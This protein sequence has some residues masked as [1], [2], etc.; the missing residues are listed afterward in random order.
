MGCMNV[1]AHMRLLLRYHFH[2]LKIILAAALFGGQ[3]PAFAEPA[4][5]SVPSRTIEEATRPGEPSVFGTIALPVR[6]QPTST[7]WTKLMNASLDQPRLVA[8][9]AEARALTAEDKVAFV[10]DILDR[11]TVL[12]KDSADCSDDGY[13][14]PAEETFSRGKG[15]CFD[16][17]VAKMEALRLLGIPSDDLMLT[18]GYFGKGIESSRGHESVALLVRIGQRFW[19]LS[20]G[21]E[22]II[23]ADQSADNAVGFSPVLTYGVGK[24][25]IHGRIRPVPASQLSTA[26][27]G[28]QANQTRPMAK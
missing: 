21:S 24:T 13:W 4:Q 18:T 19:L 8:L 25:W 14:A 28:V 22:R 27:A 2:P 10:Q 7:R 9:T 26:D 20:E 1:T 3:S 23:E 15:D 11:M 16:I 17:A 6:A 5:L 12:N